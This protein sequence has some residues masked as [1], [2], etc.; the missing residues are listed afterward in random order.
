MILLKLK[1]V[2]IKNF[3]EV[4]PVLISNTSNSCANVRYTCKAS[5]LQD[6]S[7]RANLL[8]GIINNQ[9]IHH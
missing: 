2:F 1:N 3:Y 9:D 6:C 4:Q 7:S 5:E 8:L